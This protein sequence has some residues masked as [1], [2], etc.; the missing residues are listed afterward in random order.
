MPKTTGTILHV[1]INV[2]EHKIYCIN[3][4]IQRWMFCGVIMPAIYATF[5]ITAIEIA[6]HGQFPV[7]QKCQSIAGIYRRF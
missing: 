3:A 6:L 2:P 4:L 7:Q 1:Q 5:A